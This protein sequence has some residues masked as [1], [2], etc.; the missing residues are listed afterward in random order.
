M[1]IIDVRTPAEFG[2]GHVAG[3][4]NI[5]LREI[6]QKAAEIKEMQQPL[7]ICC[8]SGGRSQQA[9]AFLKSKGVACE[10]GGSWVSVN[11]RI[12]DTEKK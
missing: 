7:I 10:D 2:G 3:S 12:S 1:T 4:I 9:T 11:Y 8:A 5:P 6:P